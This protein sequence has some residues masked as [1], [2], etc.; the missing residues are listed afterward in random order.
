VNGWT[1]F[2]LILAIG[3][4]LAVLIGALCWPTRIPKGRTVDGIRRRIEDED[5]DFH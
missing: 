2:G 1:V 4:P 3:L 5:D